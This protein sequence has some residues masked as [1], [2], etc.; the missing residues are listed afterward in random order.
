MDFLKNQLGRL[1]QQFNQLTASQKMLALSL[2]A[3]MAMTLVWWG[4]YAGTAEME[5]LLDQDISSD[6]FARISSDLKQHGIPYSASGSRILVPADRRLEA[7]AA[8]GSD[9]MLPKDFS[10]AFL[11]IVG[12][13]DNPLNSHDRSEAIRNEARQATL[14]GILRYFPKVSTAAVMLD[15]TMK[16]SFDSPVNARASIYLKLKSGEKADNRLVD[17]A[18]DMV[19]GAVAGL[20]RQNVKVIVDGVSRLFTNEDGSDNTFAGGSY[21]ERVREAESYYAAVVQSQLSFCDGVMVHV[22]VTPKVDSSHTEI[23]SVDPKVISKEISN[24]HEITTTASGARPSGEPGVGPN[25]GSNQGMAIG[26][27]NSAAAAS[28]GETVKTEKDVTKLENFVNRTRKTTSTPAGSVVVTSASVTFPRSFF[29]KAYKNLKGAD[30]EPAE[31][32]LLPFI[33]SELEK[34]RKVVKTCLNLPAEE[35]LVVDTYVDLL[36]TLADAPVQ[37]AGVALLVTS[38]GKEIVLGVLALASLF[39]VSMMVRKGSGSTL[40]LAGERIAGHSAS[41]SNMPSV[42]STVD[43]M[44][45]KSGL[46]AMVSDDAAEVG[47]GGQ[48][49]DG[50]ELDDSTIRAQQVEEQ[51]GNLAKENP[52]VAAN[53]IKRWMS[54]A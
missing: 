41:G 28:D 33:A 47:A 8:V 21:L 46:K 27:G 52:D 29:V 5:P 22:N 4:H 25:T 53:M 54:R 49:L 23:D 17:A 34:W 1:Q 42:G 32:V 26:G 6:E 18:A 3:I 50:I 31:A 38:H 30:K 15:T 43:A 24:E 48:T 35:S 9:Q 20:Q 44:L 36:P 2:V 7:M 39:M 51:V 11:D 12:K 16:R 10:S 45:V 19:C 37:S 13:M 40:A 14:A